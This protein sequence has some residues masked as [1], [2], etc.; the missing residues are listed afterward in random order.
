MQPKLIKQIK[1]NGVQLNMYLGKYMSDNRY[2]IMARDADTH[3]E[4]G[5]FTKNF[6]DI[7]LEDD[8][9]IVPGDYSEHVGKLKSLVDSN[10][11][12]IPVYS[13]KQGYGEYH[14]CTLKPEILKA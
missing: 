9:V 14:V 11:V 3:E 7:P 2:A 12:E 6:P 5:V 1:H 13:F 8:Q 10:F 4:Y